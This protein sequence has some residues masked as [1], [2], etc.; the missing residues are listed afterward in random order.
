MT[1]S[2][3]QQL[4]ACIQELWAFRLF[5]DSFRACVRLSDGAAESLACSRDLLLFARLFA[6]AEAPVPEPDIMRIWTKQ[7]ATAGELLLV[8]NILQ[9]VRGVIANKQGIGIRVEAKHAAAELALQPERRTTPGM[10]QV[11]GRH[12]FEILGWPVNTSAATVAKV[13]AQCVADSGWRPWCV[14][15]LAHT[16][17]VNTRART[18]QNRLILADRTKLLIN[19]LPTAEVA[20]KQQIGRKL[21]ATKGGGTQRRLDARQASA[22]TSHIQPDP[23]QAYLNQSHKRG[24]AKQP[25]RGDNA[26]GQVAALRREVVQLARRVDQQEERL[27]CLNPK[28]GQ[29]QEVMHALQA[30][31][32]SASSASSARK[33]APEFEGVDWSQ[34]PEGCEF[35]TVPATSVS[36]FSALCS[37]AETAEHVTPKQ[38]CVR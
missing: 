34:S 7:F 9:G 33:R 17:K 28:L 6:H 26:N 12:R 32:L 8:V 29:H 22:D 15:P 27:D 30:L 38:H 10:S 24:T 16:H 11:A 23:W 2:L 18:P 19:E 20:K 5:P 4:Q 25:N 31:A 37:C 1:G 21:A 13:L 3:R 14:L 36:R 35:L